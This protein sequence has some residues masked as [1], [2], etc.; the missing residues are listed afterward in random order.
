[1]KK[2]EMIWREILFSRL[3]KG[4]IEFT[5]KKLAENL[6]FSTSTVSLALSPLRQSGA[7]KV[8]GR[9]FRLVDPKKVL[10]HWASYR[11]LE[12]EEIYET[13]TDLPVKEI[14]SS[15]PPQAVYAAY[16]A[17][18]KRFNEAPADYDAVYFYIPKD[19]L[20][21]VKKR[22]PKKKGASNL[23]TLTAD[24]YLSKYG[25]LTTLSQTFVDLW[26]LPQWFARDFY[27]A[28]EEKIDALLA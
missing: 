2:V 13:R 11:N 4:V 8:T 9:N 22:F 21:E 23:I 10:Y 7:V 20:S 3:E 14:E 12:K 24:S 19:A 6:G 15:L 25:P 26:N 28:L 27:L 5:Q 1:M 18:T 16:S 17:Y